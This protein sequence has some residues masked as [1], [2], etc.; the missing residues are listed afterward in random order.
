MK[1]RK[2]KQMHT[3]SIEV[4]YDILLHF[5][6][7]KSTLKHKLDQHILII[8]LIVFVSYTNHWYS[9]ARCGET[10]KALN[11]AV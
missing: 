10:V 4:H 8:T 6:D 2:R 11:V 7:I 5:Q 9:E 3:G 1:L